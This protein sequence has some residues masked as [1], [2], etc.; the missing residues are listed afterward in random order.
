MS[1]AGVHR[2]FLGAKNAQELAKKRYYIYK[3]YLYMD[4]E[5]NEYLEKKKE[6]II[7]DIYIQ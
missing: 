1:G 3:L 7:L 4:L 2:Q 5:P 6:Q